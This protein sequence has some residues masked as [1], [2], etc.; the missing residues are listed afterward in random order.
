MEINSRYRAD[1]K[2]S[3]SPIRERAIWADTPAASLL[4]NCYY[5]DPPSITAYVSRYY[6]TFVSKYTR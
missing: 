6:M 4:A 3:S 5:D 1:I 2:R